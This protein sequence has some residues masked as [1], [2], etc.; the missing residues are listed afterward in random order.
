MATSKELLLIGLMSMNNKTRNVLTL[1]Y[2]GDAIYELI[3]R[4]YILEKGT[5]KV[6][7]LQHMAIKYVSAK[8]QSE[9][10]NTLINENILT[11]EELDIIY[12]ARNNTSGRH[13]KNT[14]IITYKRATALEALFGYLFL[15]QNYDRINE[16]MN[17]IIGE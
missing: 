5:Y 11:E 10:L 17:Y 6:N 12:R 14:D 8:S 1:A 2:I 4:K 13:P 3:I 7:D 16:L 9:F 15:E